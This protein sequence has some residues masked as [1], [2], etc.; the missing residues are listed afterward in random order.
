M[1]KLFFISLFFL[2][3]CTYTKPV[4]TEVEK[5][6]HGN[7]KVEKCIIKYSPFMGISSENCAHHKI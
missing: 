1:Q 2:N 5:D 7:L 3:A 4:I 6:N